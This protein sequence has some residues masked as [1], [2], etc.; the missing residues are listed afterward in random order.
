MR[1]FARLH[2]GNVVV[3]VLLSIPALPER[4]REVN[5]MVTAARK[6][7]ARGLCQGLRQLAVRDARAFGP[8]RGRHRVLQPPKAGLDTGFVEVPGGVPVRHSEVLAGGLYAA[9]C[10]GR[11]ARIADLALAAADLDQHD[12]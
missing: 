8:A 2:L 11:E 5:V 10:P 6:G 7:P 1:R 4:G 12:L 9:E 3:D